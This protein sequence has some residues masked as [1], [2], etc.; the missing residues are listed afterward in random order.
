MC[1]P[2]F[3]FYDV[4]RGL[5]ALVKWAT[6]H[7]RALPMEGIASTVTHLVAAF[8]DGVVRVQRQAF[9]GARSL[10]RV[11]GEWQRRPSAS[12]FSLLEGTSEV[13]APSPVLTR[14]WATA[15]AELAR[16]VELG[17]VT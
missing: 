2:R 14:R 9:A 10:V 7:E 11:D 3:Y 8:P 15:R 12:S 5:C 6:A 16:L 1:F 4:L 17:R 13:G